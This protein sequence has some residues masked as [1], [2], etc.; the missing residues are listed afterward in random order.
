MCTRVM[1]NR[2]VLI[3]SSVRA[4]IRK[5]GPDLHLGHMSGRVK[6]M[7]FQRSSHADMQKQ[8]MERWLLAPTNSVARVCSPVGA[9]SPIWLGAAEQP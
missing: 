9:T 4:H 6:M 1:C 8:S 5:K 7:T 2:Y 3:Y